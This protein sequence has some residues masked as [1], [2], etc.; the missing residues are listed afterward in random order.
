LTRRQRTLRATTWLDVFSGWPQV[1]S[2][3]KEPT[4]IPASLCDLLQSLGAEGWTGALH[5]AGTPGG[6]LYLVDGHLTYAESPACP[7]LGER[8][9][10]SG[11]LSAAAWRAA[12]EEG[13]DGHRVG[14]TLVR[15]GHLGRHE[16][17]CRAVATIGDA[18]HA[19]LQGDDARVRLVPGQRHWL[20]VIARVDL[21]AL[22]RETARRLRTAPPRNEPVPYRRRASWRAAPGRNAGTVKQAI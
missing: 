9:V 2:S 11:R 4:L 19:V 16:L 7:G 20:G 22:V 6:V 21:G 13:R 8:L 3:S 18:T 15:D 12:Y 17:A 1:T 5:L 14:R 10:A